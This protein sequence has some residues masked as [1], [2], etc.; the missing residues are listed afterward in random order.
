MTLASA[1]AAVHGPQVHRRG[2][3]IQNEAGESLRM[4]PIPRAHPPDAARLPLTRPAPR[5]V[6]GL[7]SASA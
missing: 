2:G 5:P 6:L 3:Q 1:G 7:L 4:L